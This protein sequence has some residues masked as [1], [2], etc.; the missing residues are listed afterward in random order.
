MWM[1]RHDRAAAALTS[2]LVNRKEKLQMYRIWL[3]VKAKKAAAG[4]EGVP[5]S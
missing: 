4:K 3:Q 1:C 2:Q 5:A